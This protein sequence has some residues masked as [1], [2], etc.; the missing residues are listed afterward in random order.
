M[1]R[2]ILHITVPAFPIALSRV[3]DSAL[4]GRPV[5]VAPL[6]SERALLQCVSS[7][8]ASDGVFAGTPIFRARKVCPSLI[9]IPPDPD[10]LARGSRALS[11]LSGEFTPVVE[12]GQG[13]VFLDLT[14]SRRLFGPAR[15]VAARLEKRIAGEMGLQAMAGAGINKL[16]SRVAADALPEPGVFDVFPGSE[17]DFLAPFPVSVLPGVGE[18]RQQILFRDLNLQFVEHVAR[19]TVPQLRLAVGPFAPLLHDRACGIDRSPVQPPRQSGEIVEEGLLSREEN[20]DEVI[21]SELLRLVEGCGLRLRRLRKGAREIALA[22]TYADG[23][24]EEGKRLLKRPVSLDLM[25]LAEVEELFYS[26]CK[27]RQ[28]VRALR[29]SCGRIGEDAGQMELFAPE[30]GEVSPRQLALQETLDA[31]REKHG[32]GV[33]CWGKGIVPGRESVAV[34]EDAPEWDPE[35]TRYMTLTKSGK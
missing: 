29:L 22:V 18:A 32:K 20:D 25:L 14:A 30:V 31:L 34:A 26:T 8:A 2:E 17:K 5:A 16:V 9:V 15:D 1:D 4:R 24:T 6:N 12:P 23:V 19:L 28:R 13:R 10:L 3:V 35:R 21:L 7:E 27:R 33:V 11:E